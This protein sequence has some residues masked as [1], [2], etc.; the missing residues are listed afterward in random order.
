MRIKQG[1]RATI[2][3]GVLVS[4]QSVWAAGP[5]PGMAIAPLVAGLQGGSRPQALPVVLPARPAKASVGAAINNAPVRYKVRAGDSLEIK[6]M[7][8]PELTQAVTVAPDG[9]II[10]PY[11]GEVVV[12]GDTLIQIINKLKV[13]LRRQFENP[14]PLV[15]VLKRQM[16][17]VSILGPVKD[18]G[19]VELGDDWHVLNLIAAAGGLTVE[20]PEFVTMK[21]VRKGGQLTYNVDPVQLFASSDPALNYTLEDGDLL[22][23]QERDKNETMV[24]VL[25]EVGKPGFVVA[26]RDG[27]PAAALAA[28]GGASSKAALSK[29]TIRRGRGGTSIP[30]DLSHP[31]TLARSLQLGPGDTLVI[32]ASISQ[33]FITGGGVAR[34]GV[35]ELPDN[36]Q[37]TIYWA[38]QQAGGANQSADLKNA[39]ITRLA[40]NGTPITDKIDLEKVL[41]NRMAQGREAEEASKLN[42]MLKPGDILE[43]PV[44]GTRSKGFRFGMNEMMMGL[45]TFLMIREV[46][47]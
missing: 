16:G 10:Y 41:K 21:L 20:R 14:Q 3:L 29:A 8:R 18:P 47:K 33:V 9:T 45:S 37:P 30:V 2:L 42:R 40:P 39:S 32:P 27:S 34:P 24:Q 22:V 35:V 1:K 12:A 44:K 4:G 26:P 31:E 46:A 7:G 13:G 28:A 36:V 43:I 17:E 19:K 6:I 11:I 15:S 5:I 25:G 23:V 38:V